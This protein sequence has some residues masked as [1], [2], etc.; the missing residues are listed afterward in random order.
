M[1][2]DNSTRSVDNTKRA[3]NSGRPNFSQ[4]ASALGYFLYECVTKCVILLNLMFFIINQ[5]K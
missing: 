1:E 4:R 5:N 2:T 3:A